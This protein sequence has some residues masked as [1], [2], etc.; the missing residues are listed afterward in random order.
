[1]L[2]TY[3]KILDMK[4]QKIKVLPD[5]DMSLEALQNFEGWPTTRDQ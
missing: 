3:L 5:V 2:F 4:N 1:M